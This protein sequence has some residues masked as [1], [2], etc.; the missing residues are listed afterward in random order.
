MAVWE[1]QEQRMDAVIKSLDDPPPPP[2]APRD[3]FPGGGPRD[4][5]DPKTW[6]N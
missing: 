1:A 6:M 3:L 4:K 5:G 2:P